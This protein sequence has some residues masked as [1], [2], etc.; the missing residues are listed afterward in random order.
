M[1]LKIR[2]APMCPYF[3]TISLAFVGPPTIKVQLLPYNRVRLMRIPILQVCPLCP[4]MHWYG[5][6]SC[7]LLGLN[8]PASK[9]ALIRCTEAAGVCLS[10]LEL[11]QDTADM[12]CSGR[13][14]G[15]QHAS[16]RLHGRA[17]TCS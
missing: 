17:E 3:G 15:I 10:C 5:H 6:G 1:W 11:R 7:L 13:D 2:L 12:H 14:E 16:T 9:T 4:S 8:Q